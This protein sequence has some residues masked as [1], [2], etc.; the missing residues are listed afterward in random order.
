MIGSLGT[1]SLA[2]RYGLIKCFWYNN[3]LATVAAALMGF[4]KLASSYEMIV[5]G[6]FIIFIAN[7]IHIFNCSFYNSD[8]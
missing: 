6:K 5:I 4:S 7:P 3:V 8:N 1:G 2:K